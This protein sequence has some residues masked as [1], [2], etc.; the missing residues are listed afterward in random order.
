MINLRGKTAIVTGG[1]MGVGLDTARRLLAEGCD[2]T[3]W[4][5]NEPALAG[6]VKELETVSGGRVFAYTADVSDRDRVLALV[7]KARQDMGRIDILINNAAF[8]RPGFFTERP[9]EEAVRQM[10]V[11]VNSLFY[12]IHA[13]LPE[14][15]ERDS[16]HIV[17]VASG[18][19]FVSTPGL[20]AYV[21]SKWATWGLTDVLRME[22][23]AM[24]KKG[25][26]FSSIH[27]GN[28]LTGMFEGFKLNWLGALITPPVKNHDIIARA[29]VE[30]ALKRGQQVVARPRTLKVPVALRGIIPDRLGNRLALLLGAGQC[31]K[32]YKGRQGHIHCYDNKK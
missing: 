14:M 31:V 2:V 29:I 7:E 20:A 26:R 3:I 6:A 15:L 8:V 27:P 25:V 23:Q 30:S 22:A 28:I 9:V 10:D 1:A 4:D 32:D 24:G 16:G 11:N 13:V 18:V 19:A 21:T 17:N 5:I 12:T